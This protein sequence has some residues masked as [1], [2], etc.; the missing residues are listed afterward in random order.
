MHELMLNGFGVQGLYPFINRN[1]ISCAKP[2]GPSIQLLDTGLKCGQVFLWNNVGLVHLSLLS[3]PNR[4]A[5][6]RARWA[7]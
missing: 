4:R 7:A 3:Q 5:N 2:L 6:R 1:T